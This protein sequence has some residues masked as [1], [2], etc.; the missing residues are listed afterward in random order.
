M[1]SWITS[2]VKN[3]IKKDRGNWTTHVQATFVSAETTDPNLSNV[4]VLGT[5]HRYVRKLASVGTMTAGQNL[6]CLNG[7]GIPLTIIGVCVGDIRK[8]V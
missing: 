4:K 6:L 2:L 8:T 1:T 3:L 7:G 5:T